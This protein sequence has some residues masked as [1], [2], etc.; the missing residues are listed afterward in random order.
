MATFFVVKKDFGF[1]PVNDND[2][3][4]CKKF[5]D[6]EVYRC[7]IKKPRNLKFHRKFFAL[8]QYVFE[9]QE[10]Y[11]TVED[12]RVEIELKAG[13]YTEHITTKGKL[14]YI[15]KSIAFEKM[16]NVEFEA[17]YNKAIDVVLKDFINGT[18][19]EIEAQEQ[20]ILAYT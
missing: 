4:V 20:E 8:L 3:E 15:P 7:E 18:K 13:N 6:G 2:Q 12:L 17:L 11:D 19:E 10:K 14:I 16:D 1:F 5:A 9:N